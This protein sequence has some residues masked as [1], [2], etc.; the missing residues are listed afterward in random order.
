[1]V[2]AQQCTCV[3]ANPVQCLA[4]R[5]S[6]STALSICMDGCECRCHKLHGGALVPSGEWQANKKRVA[7]P[8]RPARE[9]QP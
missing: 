8:V 9:V 4:T 2:S 6:I 3:D 5:H 1:M 7:R